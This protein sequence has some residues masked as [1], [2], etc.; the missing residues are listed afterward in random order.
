MCSLPYLSEQNKKEEIVLRLQNGADVNE[1]DSY[2]ITALCNACLFNT[3]IAEILLQDNKINVNLRCNSG[4]SPLFFACADNIHESIL[5]MLQDAR[6]DVN[7]AND[8]GWS[9]LMGACYF[10]YTTTV[11]LLLS[12]GRSIDIHKKSTKDF[13]IDSGSTALDIAKQTNKTKIVQLLEQYQKN[14]KETQKTLRNQLN[15]KGKKKKSKTVT[16]YIK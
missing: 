13:G 8:S 14:T 16:K 15:L 1:Q 11:Q 4:S 6:V 10:G 3:E 7:M 12:S 2:G 5:L 9:P